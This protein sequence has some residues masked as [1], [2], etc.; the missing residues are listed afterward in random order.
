M[1]DEFEALKNPVLLPKRHH[2]VD[3]IICH[4]HLQSGHSGIRYVLS[5]IREKYW[6]INERVSVRRVLSSCFNC[7]RRSQRPNQQKM[8]DLP[9]DR[10]I[11]NH[12]PFTFV[13]VD[14]FG[15]FMVKKGRAIAKRYGVLFTCLT[16]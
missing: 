1:P 8:T 14:C 7:R 15:P 9:P 12:P 13:G 2:I 11:P 6:I 4:Y 10:I 5:K 16:M 3:I